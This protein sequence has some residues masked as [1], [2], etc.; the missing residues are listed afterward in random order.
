MWVASKDVRD[1]GVM[2][3]LDHVRKITL[4]D[5]PDYTSLRFDYMAEGQYQEIEYDNAEE[6]ARVIDEIKSIL[7]DRVGFLE[8]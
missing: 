7:T 6:R 5:E 2:I 1:G 3:N 4:V 8:A